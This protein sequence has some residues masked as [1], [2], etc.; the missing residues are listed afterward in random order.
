MTA[1]GRIHGTS[2]GIRPETLEPSQLC[3]RGPL[4]IDCRMAR[5]VVDPRQR[6]ALA[7]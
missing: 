7:S 1:L 2:V 3:A 6:G 5:R 4:T